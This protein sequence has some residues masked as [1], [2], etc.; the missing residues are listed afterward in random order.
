MPYSS[1]LTNEAQGFLSRK[2]QAWCRV[3][4][5]VIMQE[6][7]T[8]RPAVQVGGLKLLDMSCR[9][10][11]SVGSATSPAQA[12]WQRKRHWYAPEPNMLL[13]GAIQSAQ[14]TLTRLTTPDDVPS[15]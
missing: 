1:V 4:L 7:P 14:G 5:S 9:K 8:R 15:L 13:L 12:I 3:I 10:A 11:L 6:Y 2:E